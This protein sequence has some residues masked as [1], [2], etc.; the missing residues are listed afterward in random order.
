MTIASIDKAKSAPPSDRATVMRPIAGP[1]ALTLTDF[2]LAEV[3]YRVDEHLLSGHATAYGASGPHGRDGRWSARPRDTAQYATR[4]VVVRPVDATLFNGTVVVEWLNVSA[5]ADTAPEWGYTHRELIRSG[6]AW[7]GVSAQKAG[8]DGGG[9]MAFPG[10][11]ALKKADPERYGS[12]NHPGDAF[13][14][15]IFT[16]AAKAVRAEPERLLG[17]KAAKTLIAAGESQSAGRLTTYINAIALLEQVFDGYLVHSRFGGAPGLG[18]SSILM[19]LLTALRPIHMRADT[20]VPILNIITETDLMMKRFG[21]LPA[22]QPDHDR[23]RTWEVAGTAHADTYVMGASPMDSGMASSEALARAMA[24]T[25]DLLG[26][27]LPGNINAAPQHH[28]VMMAALSA[29][30]RWVTTGEAPP[31]APRLTLEADGPAR[32]KLDDTGNAVGGIRSPWMDVPTCRLSGLAVAKSRMGA[33]FGS[34]VAL[35]PAVLSRLYP[36]GHDDYL[37]K[38]REALTA[39]INAGFILPQDRAEIEAL[40]AA[41][42]PK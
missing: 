10:M 5:G 40:A 15:D 12:L 30:N 2:D 26:L 25:C 22:R 38:F 28:Y 9:L 14:Y 29:L 6:Y 19:S 20:P 41:S 24:P 1:P 13:C 33:L 37:A 42:Y 31:T 11:E 16:Q 39:A 7:I 17:V 18:K 4:L 21:Y 27:T 32:L 35:E 36:A 8:I 34:T 3:G 23:L